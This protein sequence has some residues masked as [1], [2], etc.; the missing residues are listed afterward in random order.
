MYSE[1]ELLPISSLQHLVFCE[2][3]AALIHLEGIWDENIYTAEGR[4]LHE[5]SHKYEVETRGNLRVVRSLMIRS[6]RLGISGMT[7]VVEFHKLVYGT[8]VGIQNSGEAPLGGIDGAWKVYPVEYKRG[9]IRHVEGSEVQLCAQALCLEEMLG[10]AIDEGSIYYSKSRRRYEVCFDKQLRKLT[11]KTAERV[12][13][14]MNSGNTPAAS[15]SKKC[16]TCSLFF[17]CMPK[18]AGA[19]KSVQAYM[20]ENLNEVEKE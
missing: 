12:H 11:E 19:H 18:T 20:V 2:R 7:D 8:E 1:D 3:Q 6:L 9:A 13:D 5:R 4:I 10:V 14:L 16:D 17:S 15:Y